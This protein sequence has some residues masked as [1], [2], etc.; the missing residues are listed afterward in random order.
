MYYRQI[1]RWALGMTGDPDDAD[2]VTQEVVVRMQR[3]LGSY[4]AKS[5]FSTWLFQV[6]RNTALGIRRKI[7]RR[8]RLLFGGRPIDDREGISNEHALEQMQRSQV[9]DQVR[10]LYE[11]LPPRQR[12]VFDLADLQGIAPN[13]IGKLL[14][15]NPATVRANLYKARRAI[16]SKIMERFPEME[17]G[18]NA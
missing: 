3:R 7:A 10:T 18:T 8:R 9:L 1:Y 17:E 16:R 2:D 6:T 4:A 15:M 11:Q 12:Q 13:E 5:Q 14:R